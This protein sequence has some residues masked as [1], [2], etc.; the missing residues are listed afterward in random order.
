MPTVCMQVEKAL[1]DGNRQDQYFSNVA[2]KV[3]TKLGGINH[4]LVPSHMAWLNKSPTMIVGIDVT[5]PGPGARW[6]TPSITAVVASVDSRFVQYPASMR[7][8]KP[9]T[10]RMSKEMVDELDVMFRERLL[11]FKEKNRIYPKRILVYRDGVSEVC[12]RSRMYS[13]TAADDDILR[14]NMRLSFARSSR[15]SRMPQKASIR[16]MTVIPPL[17]S[18]YVASDT[19]RGQSFSTCFY[20][21]SDNNDIGS[22]PYHLPTRIRT[23]TLSLGPSLIRVSRE[24][25]F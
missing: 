1:V 8:Q 11:L 22:I 12:A 13:L 2:L 5:H 6:G 10:N 3:N 7:I 21:Q 20:I 16:T 24:C 19:M 4:T 14:A 25:T 15:K 17:P 9:D 18:S 23:G